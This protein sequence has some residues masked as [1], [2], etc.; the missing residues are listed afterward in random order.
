MLLTDAILDIC[1]RAGLPSTLV[2][3]SRITATT[4]LPV[5]TPGGYVIER[6]TVA[7]QALAEIC[8]AFFIDAC[9]SSGVLHFIPRYSQI[10][11]ASIPETDLGLAADHAELVESQGQ[12]ND[13]PQSVTVLY[14]DAT[15]NYQQGKQLK[16]RNPRIITV[17]TKHQLVVTLPFTLLPAQA[18]QIAEATL[19]AAWLNRTAYTFNLFRSLYLLLDPSDFVNFVYEGHT[20]TAR[21]M[22]T[23]LGQGA[24]VALEAVVEDLRTYTSTAPGGL[25]T[26]GTPSAPRAAAATL[27]W[28]FDLPL[29]RDTDANPSGCGCAVCRRTRN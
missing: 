12:E 16:A 27:L 29:L 19:Y 6:P 24:A 21:L 7:A 26:G 15:L 18:R 23:N 11:A 22:T 9:E 25:S 14:Y 17:A 2:D 10:V 13:L 5:A 3:V 1:A 20:Y 28:L 8:S 4:V